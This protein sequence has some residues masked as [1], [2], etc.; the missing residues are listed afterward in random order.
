MPNVKKMIEA[1]QGTITGDPAMLAVVLPADVP[2][3]A[4]LGVGMDRIRLVRNAK[5]VS[6]EREAAAVFQSIADPQNTLV[7]YGARIQEPPVAGPFDDR[8][9]VVEP[10][11]ANRV[12]VK[13]KA[14]APGWLS[15]AD[16]Y[17][18]GWKATVNGHEAD[19]VCANVGFKAVHVGAGESEVVFYFDGGLRD[20]VRRSIVWLASILAIILAVYLA[21]IPW[22]RVRAKW[23]RTRLTKV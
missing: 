20:W 19:V 23:R 13:V 12:L 21:L 6:D 11:R 8:V 17:H 1:R 16:A 9:I 3:R 15:D 10:F 5:F 22:R 2:F 7:I 18:P 4:S 14:A